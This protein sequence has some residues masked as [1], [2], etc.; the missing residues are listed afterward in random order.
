M[1]KIRERDIMIEGRD[2]EI[3][4]DWERTEERQTSSSSRGGG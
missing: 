4:I 1:K 3:K 2:L